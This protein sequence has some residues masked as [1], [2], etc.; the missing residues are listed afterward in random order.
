MLHGRQRLVPGAKISKAWVLNDEDL[1]FHLRAEI[2]LA[3]QRRRPLADD[4]RRT[5]Q[6]A[7]R[8]YSVAVG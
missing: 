6:A 8:D 3:D 7:T 1:G 4:G 2:A 5:H